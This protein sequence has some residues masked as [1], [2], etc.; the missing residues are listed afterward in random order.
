MSQSEF[1]SKKDFSFADTFTDI[2]LVYS[3]ATGHTEVYSVRKALKRFALK[4][5]K[6]EFRENPFFVGMLRKEFEIGFRLEHPGI[7][8]TYSFEEVENLG[9]CIVLEWVDGE[10]MATHLEKHTLDERAW[11][12]TFTELC[13]ALEYL[14]KRQIVHRDI[15]PSNVMLTSDGYHVKLIDFG[16]A[17]SPEYGSLK[18]SGGTRDY[19]APEQ[20]NPTVNPITHLSD[21]YAF[22]KLLQSVPMSKSKK[23]ERL[24]GSMSSENPSSRPQ[25]MG[26]LKKKLREAL[27]YPGRRMMIGLAGIFLIGCLLIVGVL[28]VVY[29]GIDAEDKKGVEAISATTDSVSAKP[30]QTAGVRG[31]EVGFSETLSD[32][33]QEEQRSPVRTPFK[34]ELIGEYSGGGYIYSEDYPIVMELEIKND[35]K[36]A[37]RYKNRQDFIWIQMRGLIDK[38]NIKLESVPE[39]EADFEM[40]MKFDYVFED[41]RLELSGYAEGDDGGREKVYIVLGKHL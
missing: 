35:G 2:R 1:F 23:L 28:W 29:R 27:G 14:E 11:R 13:D 25:D 37:A 6:P 12:K 36:V 39:P 20:V 21:I 38:N 22:G 41:D 19:A 32:E 34:E 3:S 10:T 4:A 9:P 7:V 33:N 18:H 30:A 31:L 8:R 17:D 40:A 26:D 15:K 24:I 16:F 5:L